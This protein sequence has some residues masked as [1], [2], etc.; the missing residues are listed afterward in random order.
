M[1][2]LNNILLAT[3]FTKMA[4]NAMNT[5]IAMCKRHNATLHIL[6]VVED[7]FMATGPESAV[8]VAANYVIP[9]LEKMA[10]T[11]LEKIE[12]ELKR[13]ADFPYKTYILFGNSF[14]SIISKASVVGADLIVMGT[15][16]ASGLRNLFLGS[17]SYNVIKN[18]NIPVLTVPSKAKALQFKKILFP[19]RAT[20]GI[21]DKYDFVEPIVLKN[22]A[23][24]LILGLSKPGESFELSN[25]EDE[26]RSI[27]QSLRQEK[28]NYRSEMRLARNFAKEIIKVAKTEKS[29]LIVINASLDYK[30]REYFVG[31][32]TQQV[33]SQS[34]VPVLCFRTAQPP[35]LQAAAMK[36]EMAYQPKLNFA[37]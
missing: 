12:A 30:W 32:F 29:E 23:E 13:N 33:I 6:H 1:N 15:H 2:T 17:T 26:I 36:E 34:P 19:L 5:A 16:G 25:V 20:K 27:A 8:Y 22:E 10:S 24:L 28:I 9:E 11:K 18:T 3:D 7:R 21:A 14:D 35:Q 37:I 31:P 4:D